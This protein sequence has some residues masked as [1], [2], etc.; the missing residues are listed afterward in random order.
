MPGVQLRLPSYLPPAVARYRLQNRDL[1]PSVTA[2][3]WQF[4]AKGNGTTELMIYSE[5]GFSWFDDGVTAAD[6]A[7]DLSSVKTGDL[8]LRIN[9]PG[10]DVFDGVAIANLIREFPGRTTAKVDAL[11]ASIASVIAVACD[12]VIMGAQSQMMIHDAS[13]FAMGNASDMHE[14]ADLLSMISDNIAGAYVSKA[15]GTAKDWRKVMLAT[16]WFNA[17]EAVDAGLADSLAADP[18]A[19][20]MPCPGCG[21]TGKVA[22]KPCPDCAGTGEVPATTAEAGSCDTCDG[23]GKIR[24]NKVRC[25]DCAGTGEAPA[26]SA[27]AEA[28]RRA[29]AGPLPRLRPAAVVVLPPA[30]VAELPL[31]EPAPFDWTAGLAAQLTTSVTSAIRPPAIDLADWRRTFDGFRDNAPALSLAERRPVELGPLPVA[32][33]PPAPSAVA[34][35]VRTGV[36]VGSINQPAVTAPALPVLDL[37]PAPERVVPAPSAPRNPLAELIGGAVDLAVKDQPEPN[38]A[39]AGPGHTPAQPPFRLDVAAL[40]RAVKESRF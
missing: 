16:K 26:T 30:A 23:T 8:V 22:G 5:I 12:E 4:T 38:T 18:A 3:F 28:V 32:V 31:A 35:A 24:G 33:L 11:A 14:M 29:Y 37:G 21:G 39:P 25:P 13:G 17:Q 20:P 10:G 7:S 1:Y 2:P 15:G 40:K 36:A 27:L 9:S 6:F 19:D 34:E